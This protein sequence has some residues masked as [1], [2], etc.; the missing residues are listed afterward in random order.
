MS[1]SM[2]QFG[3]K[4]PVLP[5]LGIC[6]TG[7]KPTP[8]KDQRQFQSSDGSMKAFSGFLLGLIAA[9]ISFGV[10]HNLA[11]P[12]CAGPLRSVMNNSDTDISLRTVH[13]QLPNQISKGLRMSGER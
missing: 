6:K 8:E 12:C 7:I 10:I 4:L 3:Q 9:D 13:L 1:V 5:R 11:S 2:A